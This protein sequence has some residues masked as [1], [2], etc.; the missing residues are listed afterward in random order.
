MAAAPVTTPTW[1]EVG[2]LLY[3]GVI[4]YIVLLFIAFVAEKRILHY[5]FQRMSLF[6]EELCAPTWETVVRGLGRDDAFEQRDAALSRD[7]AERESQRGGGRYLVS[8]DVLGNMGVYVAV[9]SMLASIAICTM[10]VWVTYL[11]QIEKT[12]LIIMRI[13]GALLVIQVVDKVVNSPKPGRAVRTGETV[14]EV[15]SLASLI[16]AREND[17]L[18]FSFL[19]GYVLLARYFQVEPVLELVF[20]KK[21]SPFRRQLTRLTCEFVVFI[22]VFACGLQLFER[23]G[24][25]WP[26][27]T[28][29]TFELTFANSFYYTVVTIF[30]VGYGD[31]VPYTLMGRLWII[32]IIVFGAYLVSTKVA[33]VADVISGLRRGLGSFVKGE[34]VEHCVICGNIKWEYLQSFVQ[35]FYHEPGNREKK[36]VVICDNPNWS[37]ETWNRFFSLHA[38]VRNHVTYLEGSCVSRDDLERAQVDDAKAVFVLNNQHNSDPY[39]EDSETLKRILIIRSFAPNVPIY[40]M[41]ALR[42]SMLQINY[43]L[44]HLEEIENE[45][46]ISRR[47]SM[48]GGLRLAQSE[49]MRSSDN[50]LGRTSVSPFN[51]RDGV[52]DAS[53]FNSDFPT[54]DD[55]DDDGMIVPNYDGSSDLKS[56]AICMQEVETSILA[57]NVFC[58]G[59]S[60]LLANLIL[61]V[62]PA[63][64][65]TD[66]PWAYE[67]KTGSECRFDYVKLP[68]FLHYRKFA[69][70]A[71]LMYDHGVLL[72]ATKRYMDKKWRA[73]EPENTISPNSVGLVITNHDS[74]WLKITMNMIG[75]ALEDV[76]QD[77]D[78]E[79]SSTQSQDAPSIDEMPRHN[80]AGHLLTGEI[81]R[82]N[83][84]GDPEYAPHQMFQR[85][86][87]SL[88]ES[89]AQFDF[90]AGFDDGNYDEEDDDRED[91]DELSHLQ[92]IVD[93]A[94]GL[95]SSSMLRTNESE[96]SDDTGD[97]DEDGAD[98][99]DVDDMLNIGRQV[100]ETNISAVEETV[101]PPSKSQF[102]PEPRRKRVSVV[103]RNLP[104]IAFQGTR[105]PRSQAMNF[106][107]ES[108]KATSESRPHG[109]SSGARGQVVNIRAD[110]SGPSTQRASYVDKTI[111]LDKSVPSQ[112]ASSNRHGG[113]RKR[114][115]A[116]QHV[117]FP[118]QKSDNSAEPVLDL[119]KKKKENTPF[120]FYGDDEM[121]IQMRGHIV[122]CVIGQMAM[123][124]LKHF[125][126]RVWISR[127]HSQGDTPVVA[128]CPRLTEEDE[129]ELSGYASGPLFLI[130]GNSLS[131]KTLERAH[132]AEAKAILILAC[133]DK[134]DVDHMD[135]KAIFTV[136]TLD[137]L[138]LEQSETFVC[139]MLD[140]EESMQLLRAPSKPRRR[141]ADLATDGPH[142]LEF[143]SP[144]A[145]TRD[146]VSHLT[147]EYPYSAWNRRHSTRMDSKRSFGDR[148]LSFTDFA[149]LPRST[150]FA[151]SAFFRSGSNRI[152]RQRDSMN[153]Y[154]PR[155][156]LMSY[157]SQRTRNAMDD[158]GILHNTSMGGASALNFMMNPSSLTLGG[159]GGAGGVG[160]G[161]AGLDRGRKVNGHIYDRA[162][163]ESF[164]KQRYASGEMMISSTYVSLLI[165]EYAMPGLMEVVRKIFGAGVGKTAES[166][167]S[168]IRTIRVP[169]NWIQSSE[170]GKR[171]YRELFETLIGHGAV[172][173]GL[174][175]AGDGIV[176]V[177]HKMVERGISDTPSD[178][179]PASPQ[180]TSNMNSSTYDR[181]P[182]PKDMDSPDLS[183]GSRGIE[184][185]G[186]S[187]PRMRTS[188][189]FETGG[190]LQNLPSYGAMDGRDEDEVQPVHREE[191]T[192]RAENGGPSRFTIPAEVIYDMAEQMHAAR[193]IMDEIPDE[194]ISTGRFTCPST[195]R[196]A[197]YVE[198]F[199]GQNVL[200]Y[201]YTNP[202]AYTVVSENDAVYVLVPPNINIPEIW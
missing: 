9:A 33:Q 166:G 102:L 75:N 190:I 144:R 127:G 163:D 49:G 6:I 198:C 81:P 73:I 38:H 197:E 131:V 113:S 165:R 123:M 17:W 126:Q 7:G 77:D 201:V 187:V 18:N 25:P 193:P 140:A 196:T 64:K 181:T 12:L 98:D 80:I 124:N 105:V 56:E 10:Y 132:F 87:S 70:I 159:G 45:D 54:D 136:M 173:L 149:G 184:I 119:K 200:P 152:I 91:D 110:E 171:I 59:L 24:D 179:G 40:S 31:F 89:Q 42:D 156:S 55:D 76:Y 29:T 95:T 150:S 53:Y 191:E 141:G 186:D 121:P 134:N 39:A 170:N 162:R 85:T 97:I 20:M 3:W 21:T 8:A 15:F 160:F 99:E 148:M 28:A 43:A 82:Y 26:N 112:W 34:N 142:F 172:P 164:E 146:R 189:S 107:A 101:L 175:R 65:K 11:C 118:G 86:I 13:V 120:I 195:G 104:R 194:D 153:A 61:R 114:L 1:T 48:A 161:E 83:N 100:E 69:D 79:T 169:K 32:F 116:K 19:Q 117:S 143:G 47:P 151:E 63:K 157:A 60:T 72:I 129:A 168:W 74:T 23:M 96:S 84:Y 68:H 158:E 46:T 16:M 188:R 5:L 35:E 145:S 30:T 115:K 41:C 44:E 130:Q 185:G 93:R 135:A 58:N 67:Y 14:M 27:L 94:A 4:F 88:S 167:Q 106:S 71:V 108:N 109:D 133:E 202:E 92:S 138:L 125:L 52:M 180:T 139:T 128:I 103:D 182:P 2:R 199:G 66:H 178:L 147:S 51:T 50:L 176:R 90:G 174:Y 57:E 183:I 111:E 37:E 137:H 62:N 155:P 22:Y 177:L 122:V 78:D 36:L 154:G 192:V